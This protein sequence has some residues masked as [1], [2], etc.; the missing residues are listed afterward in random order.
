[1]ADPSPRTINGHIKW[2]SPETTYACEG[3]REYLQHSQID[4]D[5]TK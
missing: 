5:Q 1:M 3:Q 4:Q 2:P